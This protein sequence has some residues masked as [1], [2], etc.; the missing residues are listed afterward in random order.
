[1]FDQIQLTGFQCHANTL[2][3]F[4]RVTVLVGDNDS[5]KSAVIRALLWLCLNQWGGGSAD[6]FI[7]WDSEVCEVS[8]L[9]DEDSITRKKGKGVSLYTLNDQEFR[10]FGTKIP[11]PI[12]KSLN[13]GPDNFQGQHDSPFWMML[14]SG[15]AA[16]A[17]N[18]IFNLSKIDIAH[19]NIAGELRQARS[20]AGAAKERLDQASLVVFSLQWVE[21]ADKDLKQIETLEKQL[22]SGRKQITELERTIGESEAMEQYEQELTE[23][24][25]IGKKLIW[26]MEELIGINQKVNKIKEL[27]DAEARLESLSKS[28]NNKEKQLKK[29]LTETCPLCGRED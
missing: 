24:I 2:I 15:Q 25:T 26:I 3:N 12:V 21:K 23:A 9:C 29:W 28:L 10:A 5:G 8:L 14:N 7:N 18:D 17:L 11:E 4:D 19:S 16:A 27:I 20:R 13:V 1:M 6:S 22:E